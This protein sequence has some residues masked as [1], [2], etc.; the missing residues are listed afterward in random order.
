MFSQVWWAFV[1]L[2][3]PY[4]GDALFL[5]LSSRVIYLFQLC[6]NLFRDEGQE[7][8]TQQNCCI[9]WEKK[10]SHV[11]FHFFL[12]ASSTLHVFLSIVENWSDVFIELTS[13]T[14]RLP[15]SVRTANSE[16]NIC[17]FGI[18]FLQIHLDMTKLSFT[19]HYPVTWYWEI[20]PLN[21]SL[22]S[23]CHPT[24]HNNPQNKQKSAYHKFKPRINNAQ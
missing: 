14:P 13:V 6:Y 2:I 22:S 19:C 24:M 9:Q 16:S 15:F 12:M 5:W 20:L 3:I 10:Y 7:R 1:N 8:T 17:K 4:T 11:F 18:V 21:S 23:N